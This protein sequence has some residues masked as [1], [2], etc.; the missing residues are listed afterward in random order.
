MAD[1]NLV[2]ALE[3]EFPSLEWLSS[4]LFNL[5]KLLLNKSKQIQ[6]KNATQKNELILQKIQEEIEKITGESSIKLAF[7]KRVEDISDYFL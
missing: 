2:T 4:I 6:G 1:L 5:F 3:K 7:P